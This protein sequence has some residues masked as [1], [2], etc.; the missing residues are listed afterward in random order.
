MV[1]IHQIIDCRICNEKTDIRLP[2]KVFESGGLLFF[3][4][5]CE[6]EYLVTKY[7]VEFF[8]ERARFEPYSYLAIHY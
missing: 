3:C 7:G 2:E 8:K 1:E 6:A 5:K 4:K